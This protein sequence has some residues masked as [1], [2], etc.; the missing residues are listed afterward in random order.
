MIRM[1]EKGGP[2]PQEK[3]GE[4]LHFFRALMCAVLAEIYTSGVL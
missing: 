4:R 2:P 1:R 3:R